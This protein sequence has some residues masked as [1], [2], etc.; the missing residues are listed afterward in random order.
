[1]RE[2]PEGSL[3][4]SARL[5][6]FRPREESFMDQGVNILAGSRKNNTFL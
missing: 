4:G 6:A 5:K 3:L 2:D 1:M